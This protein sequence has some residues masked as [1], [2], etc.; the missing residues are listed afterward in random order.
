MEIGEV[1]IKINQFGDT[2]SKAGVTPAQVQYLIHEH[3]LNAGEMPV[4]GLSITGSEERTS[5]AEKIRLAGIFPQNR[6]PKL[7]SLEKLFPGA[8]A[9]LPE[10]FA[11][12]VDQ[13]GNKPFAK[14]GK[15]RDT[16]KTVIGGK[17]Y[18][19]EELEKLV[20]AAKPATPANVPPAAKPST[21]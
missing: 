21:T 4:K 19:Q 3:S 1:T 8:N 11:E 18:S 2:V 9:K 15:I 16:K 20:A 12:V 10:T 5:A 7:V 13:Q 14:D 17:E 6:D